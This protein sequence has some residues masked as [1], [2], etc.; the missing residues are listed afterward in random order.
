MYMATD[1]Q[2]KAGIYNRCTTI[3]TLM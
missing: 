3:T 2:D 1:K